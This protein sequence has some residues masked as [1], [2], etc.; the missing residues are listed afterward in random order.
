LHYF[1]YSFYLL[2]IQIY[3]RHWQRPD[4]RQRWNAYSR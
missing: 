2:S 1:F 4:S 3:I